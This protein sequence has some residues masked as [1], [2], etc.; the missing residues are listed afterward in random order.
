LRRDRSL[1]E[2]RGA[3]RSAAEETDRLTQLAEDLLTIAQTDRGELPVRLERLD[4]AK[5]LGDVAARLPLPAAE[6]G[7]E[8]SRGEGSG[9][10][11]SGDRLRLEQALGNLLDNALRYGEGPVELT[12]GAVEGSVE[13]H[14]RDRGPGLPD[15]FRARAFERFSRAEPAR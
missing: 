1:E 9:L 2:L 11:V 14:V 7:R 5:V 6:R 4:T 10:T 12:A 15:E 8:L 13:L 3:L